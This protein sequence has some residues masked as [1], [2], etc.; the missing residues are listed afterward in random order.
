VTAVGRSTPAERVSDY[1]NTSPHNTAT[2]T[3]T[4]TSLLLLSDVINDVTTLPSGLNN[5]WLALLAEFD[6]ELLRLIC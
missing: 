5:R 4:V 2:A 1:V 3:G 6:S